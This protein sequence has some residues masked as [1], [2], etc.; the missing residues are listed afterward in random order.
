AR[1]RSRR[2]PTCSRRCARATKRAPPPRSRITCAARMTAWC[3]AITPP[4]RIPS[5]VLQ[6]IW[7]GTMHLVSFV[8]DNV[9]R[10]GALRE[11]D[12]RQPVVDL[13]RAEPDLPSDMLDFLAAGAEALAL[14]ERALSAASP[15]LA[16]DRS[17][18]TLKAPIPRPGKIICIGL[19]YRDHAEESN[20]QVPEYPTVFAKYASCVIGP[21]EP[22]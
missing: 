12:G 8:H 7:R 20:A 16:F 18:V 21:G 1:S 3:K 6:M 19:N 9:S 11:R 10:I 2:T 17:A 15:E 13:T 22:T 4:R 5:D 14:A